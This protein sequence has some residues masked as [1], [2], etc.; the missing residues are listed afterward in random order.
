MMIRIMQTTREDAP[1]TPFMRGL[2]LSRP[3]GVKRHSKHPVLAPKI[4]DLVRREDPA[5]A[6]H[7]RMSGLRRAVHDRLARARRLVWSHVV[8]TADGSP[9]SGARPGVLELTAVAAFQQPSLA[10]ACLGS[11]S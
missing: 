8:G 6:S 10:G 4:L 7:P 9:F 3:G 1:E 5:A 2:S 11:W